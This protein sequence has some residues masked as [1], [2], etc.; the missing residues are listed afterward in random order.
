LAL[1][2][3]LFYF[4]VCNFGP[5]SN[6]CVWF[7]PFLKLMCLILALSQIDVFDFGTF[8]NSWCSHF[9]DNP[10]IERKKSDFCQSKEQVQ[11]NLIERMG[12]GCNFAYN[13]VIWDSMFSSF[14][15]Q[16]TLS[17]LGSTKMYML[18]ILIKRSTRLL[19]F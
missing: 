2:S 7:W 14:F 8:I 3:H 19:L 12:Y 4:D 16:R 10:F 1:F 18:I 5:F 6:W 13:S 17:S 9:V 11:N 15:H